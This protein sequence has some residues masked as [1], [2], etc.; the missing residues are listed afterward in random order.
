MALRELKQIYMEALL[1]QSLKDMLYE[2]YE[3][4]GLNDTYVS[5]DTVINQTNFAFDESV[6]DEN[7][8]AMFQEAPMPKVDI[9]VVL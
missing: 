3:K 7:I 4:M 9:D 2:Q 6:L 1:A 5:Q 8:V